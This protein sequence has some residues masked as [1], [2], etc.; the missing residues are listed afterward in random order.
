MVSSRNISSSSVDHHDP[1]STWAKEQAFPSTPNYQDTA[2]HVPVRSELDSMHPAL[3][4][5]AD[6]SMQL[7]AKRRSG[8]PCTRDA[9]LAISRAGQEDRVV[10]TAK[11]VQQTDQTDHHEHKIHKKKWRPKYSA[12]QS[13]SLPSSVASLKLNTDDDNESCLGSIRHEAEES[14]FRDTRGSI[15][16]ELDIVL[17]GDGT[18]WVNK[19]AWND[20]HSSLDSSDDDSIKQGW[21]P[22]YLMD[23]VTSL[24]NSRPRPISFLEPEVETHWECDLDPEAGVMMAPIEYPQTSVNP[25]DFNTPEERARRMSG[26][27]ELKVTMVAEKLR[28]RV[29]RREQRE[30][31]QSQRCLDPKYKR[32]NTA[33]MQQDSPNHFGRLSI[34]NG[35]LPDQTTTAFGDSQPGDQRQPRISCFLRPTERGDL[36][37]ILDIYNWEVEH[38]RQALDSKPLTLQ[39]IQRVFSDCETTGRPFIVAVKGMNPLNPISGREAFARLHSR[40]SYQQP[41]RPDHDVGGKALA[42]SQSSSDKIL[43]FGLIA[44]PSAGLA[45][46]AHTSVGRFNGQ[47]QFYVDHRSRRLGIGR[48]ILHR[49]LRCC[50]KF[51]LDA[52]WYEWCNPYESRA[53]AE[54][55]HNI[56]DYARVFVEM[57]SFKG[58]PDFSWSRKLLVE[59]NFL[60]V[61]TTDL[62]RK[63]IYDARGGW[64]DNTVWQHD[65]GGPDDVR[66]SY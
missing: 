38:G 23:W 46:N 22:Q 1:S 21:L 6:Q 37:Q 43:G 60:Y 25:K 65:C 50:S 35:Q 33:Y 18:G 3:R 4:R 10:Q 2:Q 15:A 24:P 31:Q 9:W 28:K 55:G 51:L 7:E 52:D 26:T 49:L 34:G 36:P 48:C 8:V 59:M 19:H 61:N 29:E 20:Y 12:E 13:Q 63:V 54:P 17:K 57:A 56:R 11:Q 66:E 53:C 58:D 64:F 40:G 62:T 16:D 14:S 47:L 41:R 39:D 44:L 5:F 32:V 42:S 27:A 30:E 45:G